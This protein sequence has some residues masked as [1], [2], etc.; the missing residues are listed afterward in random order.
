[1]ESCDSVKNKEFIRLSNLLNE[2][3]SHNQ[4]D[5]SKETQNEKE[6][7][8]RLQKE[9][10]KV[11]SRESKLFQHNKEADECKICGAAYIEPHVCQKNK[12]SF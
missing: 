6:V 10:H 9:S 8:K 11:V 4:S 5:E 12:I 3:I 1:M 7:K 2:I